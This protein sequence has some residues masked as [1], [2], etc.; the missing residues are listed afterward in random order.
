MKIAKDFNDP[1]C[2]RALFCS[3][4]RPILEYAAVVWSPYE[5]TWITRIESVQRKFV[6]R[7]LHNLN[8]RDPLN[9]PPYE[10]RCALLGIEPLHSRRVICQAVFGAK[11]L[12]AEIDSAELLSRM[13]LYA[14]TRV[15]RPRQLIQATARN[16][17][18][19]SNDPINSICRRFQ[20][21]YDLF[22]FNL[23]TVAFRQR[24]CSMLL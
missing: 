24:L 13:R 22:D 3:L 12:K 9:L 11:I 8:W 23:S 17:R 7:A 14:P 6:R 5:T 15:L 10:S 19:G 20:E 16:T 1:T 4:V 18:Y 21:A 2:V